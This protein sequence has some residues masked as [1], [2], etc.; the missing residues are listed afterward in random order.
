MLRCATSADLHGN[1]GCGSYFEVGS[2]ACRNSKKMDRSVLDC[3]DRDYNQMNT[4][5]SFGECATLVGIISKETAEIYN[6]LFD[7]RQEGD[8][9]A[10][11]VFKKI[12]FFQE[13]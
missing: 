9:A 4:T 8:Y 10:F 11:V 7:R 3:E 12:R 6:D 5:A 13:S 1:Y 2:P